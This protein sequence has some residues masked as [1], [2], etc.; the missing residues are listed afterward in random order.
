[1][2]EKISKSDLLKIILEEV[3]SSDVVGEDIIHMLIDE[4]IARDVTELHERQLTFG[5][6]MSDKLAE[7]GSVK[8]FV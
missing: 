4:K 3:D 2:T 5:D 8:L 7:L 1:M 6:K